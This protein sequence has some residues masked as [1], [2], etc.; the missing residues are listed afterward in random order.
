MLIVCL[1]WAVTLGRYDV[2]YATNTLS[3]LG[4]KP[5]DGHTERALWVFGFL[6]HHMWDKLFFDSTQMSHEEINFKEKDWT[7]CYPDAEEYID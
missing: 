3:R 2:Q 1:Q 5:Q 6:K 4:K 7:E